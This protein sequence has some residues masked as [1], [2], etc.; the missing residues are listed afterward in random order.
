MKE[1]L[2]Q[3]KNSVDE[4]L[5]DGKTLN[6]SELRSIMLTA[7]EGLNEICQFDELKT[8]LDSSEWPNAVFQSRLQT[9]TQRKTK[10]S[11]PRE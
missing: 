5:S 4:F 8:L 11:V 10:R 2:Q 1:K 7:A 6:A 3:L 9:R